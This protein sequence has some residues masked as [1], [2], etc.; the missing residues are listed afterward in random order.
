MTEKNMKII[1]GC[2]FV[3]VAAIASIAVFYIQNIDEEIQNEESPQQI[4]RGVAY[5]T[6]VRANPDDPN[7]TDIYLHDPQTD[8]SVFFITLA[9]VY[10][11][12]YHNA[13]YHNGNLYVIRRTGYDYNSEINRDWTD[14][15]W[16]FNIKREGQRLF[17]TQGL[18]F[19]VSDDEQFI[20]ITNNDEL[21]ILNKNGDLVKTFPRADI[22]IPHS[23]PA[24]FQVLAYRQGIIWLENSFG[25]RLVGLAKINTDNYDVTIFNLFELPMQTDFA[26]NVEKEKVAYST[27]PTPVDA[28]AMDAYTHSGEKVTLAVYD[29]NTKTSQEI[30][31]SITKKFEPRWIDAQTLE[32]NNPNGNERLQRQIP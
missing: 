4:I 24:S 10:R 29:I 13:E 15:L 31:T 20:S 25:A 5:N 17:S 22:T 2:S 30:A 32:Y 28:D 23:A 12:H 19:R 21:N 6:D 26:F 11:G 27:Y 14:E 18:D 9:D 16:K 8:Q 7:K 3:I 1:L